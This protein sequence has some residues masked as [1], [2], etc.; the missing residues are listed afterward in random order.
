MESEI[1]PEEKKKE[2]A[3]HHCHVTEGDLQATN[4]S[5][6]IDEKQNSGV[7]IPQVIEQL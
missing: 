5:T 6:M 3:L 7:L 2:R 4:T 1:Q